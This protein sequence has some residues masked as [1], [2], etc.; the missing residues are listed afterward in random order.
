[1]ISNIYTRLSEI[2]LDILEH[3][4]WALLAIVNGWNIL[5]LLVIV[6]GKNIT[7]K[8]TLALIIVTKDSPMLFTK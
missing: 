8:L 6:N 2:D 5:P 7:I 1:M 3:M 4:I